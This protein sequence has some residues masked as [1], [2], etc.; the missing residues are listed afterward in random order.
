[1]PTG[2]SIILNAFIVAGKGSRRI[3]FVVQQSCRALFRENAD[4]E[5]KGSPDRIRVNAV[6]SGSNDAP[7]L[8]DW[9]SRQRTREHLKM[10]SG[11]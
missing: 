2:A 9:S 8:S 6:S 11:Q 5:P 3:V 1:M 4:Y 10:T 7:G